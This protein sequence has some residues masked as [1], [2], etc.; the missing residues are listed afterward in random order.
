MVKL[1]L[2]EYLERIKDQ[3]SWLVLLGIFMT[4]LIVVL[5]TEKFKNFL[6][7]SNTVWQAIIYISLSIWL[8]LL[9]VKAWS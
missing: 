4:L 3:R 1:I 7:I 8:A 9:L 2:K 6:D 5:T